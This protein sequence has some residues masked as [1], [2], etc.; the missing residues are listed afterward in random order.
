LIPFVRDGSLP[1]N[2]Q[3]SFSRTLWH[4]GWLSMHH[5][6]SKCPVSILVYKWRFGG[7]LVIASSQKPPRFGDDQLDPKTPDSVMGSKPWD[8]LTMMHKMGLDASSTQHPRGHAGQDT[9]A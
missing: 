2:D 6:P 5:V 1:R 8:R 3:D 9:C 4:A 7:T